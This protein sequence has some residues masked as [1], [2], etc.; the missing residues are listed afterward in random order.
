MGPRTRCVSLEGAPAVRLPG[1]LHCGEWKT[2]RKALPRKCQVPL[3]FS[4]NSCCAQCGWPTL[5]GS[6]VVSAA[7]FGHGFNSPSEG[8]MAVGFPVDQLQ[9][10][11]LRNLS[12]HTSQ[13][14]F[15]CAMQ[16]M[17]QGRVELQEKH[18]GL[19]QACTAGRLVL[20]RSS[21][22]ALDLI[23]WVRSLHPSSAGS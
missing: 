20:F 2:R 3:C 12:T 11:T 14:L 6:R 4:R 17:V 7:G 8:S 23:A 21:P 19:F 13:S 1:G 9:S 16:C 5:L 22:G 15:L 10:L 18:A